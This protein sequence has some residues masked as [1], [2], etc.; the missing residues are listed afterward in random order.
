MCAGSNLM[1]VSQYS[2]DD[3][4]KTMLKALQSPHESDD[5]FLSTSIKS[6]NRL[7]SSECLAIYQHSYYARLLSCMR[8]QFPALYHCLDKEL[9]NEFSKQYLAHCFPKSYTLYELG[10]RFPKFL[11]DTRPNQNLDENKQERW[12]N[13]MIDLASFEFRVFSL[14]DAHGNKADEFATLDTPDNDL[15]LQKC[16]E[17]S[18]Y[19][20]DVAEYYHGVRN[21]QNPSLPPL[22]NTK[23]ALVR[24]DFLTYTLFLSTPQYHFLQ[25]LKSGKTVSE[26]IINV[27]IQLNLPQEQVASSWNKPGG[28]R[29]RWIENGLFLDKKHSGSTFA[30]VDVVLF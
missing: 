29:K 27:S 23:L 17:I 18:E 2:L 15:V 11:Y 20:F 9:F 3:I 28:I 24:K 30:D 5:L 25:F 13:F 7:N 22:F 26:A 16:L 1:F 19:R 8:E 4:Q 14:F 21:K 6:N 12:V 10:R